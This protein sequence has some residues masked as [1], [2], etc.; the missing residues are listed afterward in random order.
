VEAKAAGERGAGLRYKNI[1]PNAVV[2]LPIALILLPCPTSH[3]VVKARLANYHKTIA[4]LLTFYKPVHYV[5]D[6]KVVHS[7]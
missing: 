6:A 5:V 7:T 2:N 3:T 4:P 1:F